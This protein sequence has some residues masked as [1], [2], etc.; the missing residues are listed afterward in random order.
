[1]SI[2]KSL[3]TSMLAIASVPTLIFAIFISLTTVQN[4]LNVSREAAENTARYYQQGFEAQLNTQIVELEGLASNTDIM[5]LLLKKYNDPSIDLIQDTVSRSNI[6]AILNQASS[7]FGNHVIYSVFDMNGTLTYSSDDS[8]V[9]EYSHYVEDMSAT[10]ETT[11]MN[12]TLTLNNQSEAIHIMTPVTVKNKYYVGVLVASMDAEYFNGFISETEHTYLLDTASNSLL[13]MEFEDGKIR[14]EAVARLIQSTDSDSKLTGSI[15]E[16]DMLAFDL[17]GYSIM[18]E[19]HWIY[20][21]KQ[22]TSIYES[23]FRSV[24]ILIFVILVLSLGITI[25]ITLRLIKSYC[26]PIF[27]LKEKMQQASQGDLTVSCEIDTQNEFGELSSHFNNMMQIISNN[28]DSLIET[29]EQLEQSQVELQESYGQIKTLAYTDTLTGLANRVAF[30][31]QAHEIFNR[32]GTIEKRAIFFIDLDNFKNVNDTLGHDY[33]D[34]LLQQIANQLS[35]YMSEEDILARTGGDE[36]LVLRSQLDSTDELD[37]VASDLISIAEHPFDLNGEI[38]HVSMSIGIAIFPQ[39]GL[40]VNELI[41]NADIAMYSAKSAGKNSYQFFNSSMEDEVNHKTEIEEVLHNAIQNRE[42]YLVYQPQ[43]DLK[44][45]RITGCEALMRIRNGYLGQLPPSEFIPIAEE[46]GIIKELGTW[47]LKQA[48]DFNKQLLDAGL[49]PLTMSVNVSVE[50]L[51]DDNFISIVKDILAQT[52]LPPEYLELEVT[53]S[54][55]MQSFERNVS[56]INELRDMGIR[57]ALDD[58]G[59]GYSSFNYLTQLPISTL[60]IDK[61]F[62]DNINTDPKDYYVAEAIITLAHKLGI[63][64]VAEGVETSEQQQIL[65]KNTCDIIQGYLFS[66]PIP[67]EHYRNLLEEINQE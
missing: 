56:L 51:K 61:A 15:L 27:V 59:T 3:L 41:K 8:L 1:M 9:G 55:V 57:I 30:M 29:K 63:S 2:K 37:E 13:G 42:V 24:L 54:T 39:N 49:G 45:G 23:L 25:I 38:V 22:D 26:D 58:F 40:T 17:Y 34:L 46:T 64:V 65:L 50:Q 19:Y 20:L 67:D 66:K 21:V 7:S 10:L 31:T 5:N 28:Y 52:K 12:S 53:E 60:K 11:Q 62:M 36:F 43:C 48:C 44:S 35:S 18:P 16:Q 6:N 47:A 33:G 32:S 14:R 4:Y